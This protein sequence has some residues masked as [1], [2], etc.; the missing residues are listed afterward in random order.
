MNFNTPYDDILLEVKGDQI[1]NILTKRGVPNYA[2]SE[3]SSPDWSDLRDLIHAD[4][5]GGYYRF[6]PGGTLQKPRTVII[7]YRNLIGPGDHNN[8]V[9]RYPRVGIHTRTN[10]NSRGMT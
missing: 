8:A 2:T 7:G 4:G 5:G 10:Q 3:C 9:V 1:S 6:T